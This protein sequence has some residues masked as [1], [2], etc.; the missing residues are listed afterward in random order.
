MCPTSK[1]PVLFAA[2]DFSLTDQDGRPFTSNDL[3]G[4]VVLADFIYTTCPDICP[5]ISGSMG[6]LRDELRRTRLLGNKAVL[7]SFS[8]D[9]DRDTRD[10]LRVY[11]S[12]F[13]AVPAE[14]HFLTG[15]RADV[16]DLLVAGFKLGRPFRGSR[17]DGGTELTHTSRV[18]LIDPRGQVRALYHGE[19]L[20]VQSVVADIR[21]LTA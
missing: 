19:A 14:W 3:L 12:R 11:G 10:V 18:V 5:L 21:R 16:E 9:P 17:P 1:L 8:V 4:R 2:P 20:D 15:D 6:Q 13:G 7:V